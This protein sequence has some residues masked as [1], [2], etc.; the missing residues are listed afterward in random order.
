M[1][2][3]YCRV[4]MDLLQ[5]L[6]QPSTEAE[7]SFILPFLPFTSFRELLKMEPNEKSDH[8]TETC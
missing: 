3:L 8:F 1:K 2:I 7:K 5:L 6:P 4:L